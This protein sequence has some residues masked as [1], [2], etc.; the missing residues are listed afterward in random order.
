MENGRGE[1]LDATVPRTI[2]EKASAD[3][4][5]PARPDSSPVIV[6]EV[7]GGPLDGLRRCVGGP[8]LTIGRAP[9]KDLVLSEDRMVSSHHARIARDGDR[10]W[11]EDLGSLNGSFL[12]SG[13]VEGR[14]PLR[15]GTLIMVGRTWM[16]F[17]S[18]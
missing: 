17:L 16:E 12:D 4:P 2:E 14:A 5:Q 3:R 13:R 1:R 18:N 11:L 10:C 15:R 9:G 8:V 7:V 6:V